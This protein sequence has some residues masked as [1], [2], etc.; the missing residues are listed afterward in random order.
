MSLCR[1]LTLASSVP[2]RPAS[3][4]AR[5]NITALSGGRSSAQTTCD[6]TNKESDRRSDR[7]L[8]RAL[9]VNV[10]YLGGMFPEFAFLLVRDTF[11][12]GCRTPLPQR[13]E[14]VFTPFA[15]S[16]HCASSPGPSISR[17]ASTP[18]WKRIVNEAKS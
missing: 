7:S 9:G 1:S 8:S 14:R 11:K 15:K 5:A 4:C 18:A 16:R 2:F 17:E 10:T 13:D 6:D 12:R 3:R